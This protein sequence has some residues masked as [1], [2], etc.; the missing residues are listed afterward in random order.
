LVE[1]NEKPTQIA[2]IT[3]MAQKVS[4]SIHAALLER[5]N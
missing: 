5:P 4:V 3:Q 1:A 2:Q